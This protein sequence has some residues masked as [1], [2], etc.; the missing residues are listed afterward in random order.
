MVIQLPKAKDTKVRIDQYWTENGV[1]IKEDAELEY[2]PRYSEEFL[3]N[4]IIE[5]EGL[6][7]EKQCDHESEDTRTIERAD[8][9][10]QSDVRSDTGEE[11]NDDRKIV[12]APTEKTV[13]IQIEADRESHLVDN[14]QE[15]DVMEKPSE[16]MDM[17]SQK[18]GFFGGIFG[19]K[20]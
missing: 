15:I 4:A 9:S 6:Q 18:N 17:N 12:T 13:D 8:E 2:L 20:K 14:S 19:R 10:I 7:E 3:E 11:Q 1:D 16:E 5:I